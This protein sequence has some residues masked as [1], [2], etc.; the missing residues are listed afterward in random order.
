GGLAAGAG[1]G[2][3]YLWIPKANANTN[4]FGS[5]K[6]LICIRLSG[7]FRFT[8]A[9]NSDTGDEFSPWGTASG[10]A[11]GTEWG[12]GKLLETAA[13]EGGWYT[14]ALQ[15][16]GVKK[17]TALATQVAVITCVDHEP[18]SGSADGNH[19]TGL[20]RYLTGYV[21]GQNGIFTMINY[22]LRMR[23]ELAQAEGQ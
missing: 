23:Y 12:V 4:G 22:G 20:E 11:S 19:A 13:G 21:N 9:F 1:L 5:A 14:S 10:V 6:H 18:L 2:F 8:T 17:F 3:P 7:G 16:L 15:E